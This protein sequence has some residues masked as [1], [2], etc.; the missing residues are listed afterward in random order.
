[1]TV[2]EAITESARD[3]QER[4]EAH[5]RLLAQRGSPV[6][7]GAEPAWSSDRASRGRLRR[8]LSDTIAV[9]E[10]TR[11]AFKSRELEQLRKKLIGV[12]AE[13]G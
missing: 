8:T 4:I 9:L 11:R 7:S 3:L 1:M 13:D 12:L 5:R 10:G 2:E 6:C